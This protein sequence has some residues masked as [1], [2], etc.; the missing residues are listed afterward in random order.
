MEADKLVNALV[1]NLIRRCKNNDEDAYNQL[2]AR[3][4]AY[5]YSTCYNYT[6]SREEAL[7]MM[8]EVYIRILRG[9]KTFDESRPLLPW[10]KRIAINT[11]INQGKKARL[12]EISLDGDWSG[13]NS[14]HRSP[15]VKSYPA[16]ENNTEEQVIYSDT[17]RIIDRLIGELPEAYR[18]ALTLRYHE[19]MSY[20]EIASSLEQP[21]GT[22][23]NSIYRA[24][25]ILRQ[26][27]QAC[28][29][30]EV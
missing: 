5:L 1:V 30:L 7:D 28:E 24:R 13:D 2:I 10:L 16:T 19:E 3:H 29:L 9:L 23:K 15:Q 14:D 25:K 20:E 11:M 21:L 18:L 22:V 27:M 6:R 12:N 26:K 17:R 4:E 8:Q